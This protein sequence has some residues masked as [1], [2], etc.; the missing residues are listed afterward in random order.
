[1]FCSSFETS[2]RSYAPS[3]MVMASVSTF[4]DHNATPAARVAARRCFSCQTG[5]DISLDDMALY[6]IYL[7]PSASRRH[8]RKW[9]RGRSRVQRNAA[10]LFRW[11]VFCAASGAGN[12][13]PDAFLSPCIVEWIIEILGSV[14]RGVMENTPRMRAD[15]L[16]I[17]PVN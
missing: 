7:R 16:K 12:E 2:Q 8:W 11:L 15:R 13:I 5:M 4:Q 1:M 9:T 10:K 17:A 3:S 14:S 6:L